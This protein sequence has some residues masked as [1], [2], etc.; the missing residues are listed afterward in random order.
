MLELS[1]WFRTMGQQL[2]TF[3][4]ENSKKVVAD[5]FASFLSG[6]HSYLLDSPLFGRLIFTENTNLRLKMFSIALI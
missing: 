4:D 2:V 1:Q 6:C 5:V 3:V